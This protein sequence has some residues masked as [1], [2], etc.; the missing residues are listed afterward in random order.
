MY[1]PRVSLPTESEIV[2]T[3]DI[4]EHEH[5]ALDLL[6]EQP[7]G[8]SQDAVSG[9]VRAAMGTVRGL[10]ARLGAVVT[11]TL[12]DAASELARTEDR[13]S[14]EIGMLD[15]IRLTLVENPRL[16]L[17]IAPTVETLGTIL[18]LDRDAAAWALLLDLAEQ[19]HAEA[20]DRLLNCSTA[21][22]ERLAAAQTS[23][24]GSSA[25]LPLAG[26]VSRALRV[27]RSAAVA[28]AGP[29][30]RAQLLAADHPEHLGLARALVEHHADAATLVDAF[31]QARTVL[32]S[33]VV[34]RPSPDGA[35][36]QIDGPKRKFTR[37]HVILA[38]IVLGL[39][40][41]HYV[42]R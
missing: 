10:L 18:G 31:D 20:D 40:L 3:A 13:G 24:L 14:L 15:E 25:G 16:S 19:A 32:E 8:S 36:P 28:Q 22:A 34:E 17:A 6:D 30:I 37:V 26:T 35:P 21:I 4:D 27:F 38:L 41:W 9:E 2:G 29:S 12:I 1:D 7:R 39:T 11:R 23:L 33:A 5:Q 42:F